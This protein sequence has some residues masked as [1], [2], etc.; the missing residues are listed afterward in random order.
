M[1]LLLVL[2]PSTGCG[3]SLK[4]ISLLSPLDAILCKMDGFEK[5]FLFGLSTLMEIFLLVFGLPTFLLLPLIPLSLF[6]WLCD[7]TTSDTLSLLF[8]FMLGSSRIDWLILCSA[9]D[10]RMTL[11]FG[12]VFLVIIRSFQ[13]LLN[14]AVV[15]RTVVNVSLS[16]EDLLI[17][18][19]SWRSEIKTCRLLCALSTI[20]IFVFPM[21]ND[22]KFWL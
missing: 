15:V 8:S 16:S 4:I 11:K 10:T 3:D 22:Y 1:F 17:C 5:G 6:F 20:I 9:Q 7:R 21:Y 19:F 2:I 18:W 13:I 14:S 12:F